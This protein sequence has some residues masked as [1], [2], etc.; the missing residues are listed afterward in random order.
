MLHM[1]GPAPEDDNVTTPLLHQMGRHH[2]A[3]GI[4]APSWFE[5]MGHAIVQALET[6]L[7]SMD[8]PRTSFCT[9]LTLR[10][11][12][13]WQTVYAALSSEMLQAMGPIDDDEEDEDED[14]EESISVRQE[15]Q[16]YVQRVSIQDTVEETISI[17]RG[18]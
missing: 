14:E 12:R 2:A 9:S 13:A 15:Q 6:L 1:L 8:R 3:M 11:I 4:V 10:E 18:R 16:P 7:Q 5:A 17:R